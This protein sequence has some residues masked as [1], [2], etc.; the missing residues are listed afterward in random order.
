MSSAQGSAA[1]SSP[2]R[3]DPEQLRRRCDPSIFDFETTAEIERCP[4]RIIGQDR[5]QEALRLGLTLRS[6]GYNIFVTGDVGSGRSTT[7]RRML[8]EVDSSGGPPDD[9]V[10][11]HDFAAADQPR[12]LVLPAGRGRALKR[13]MEELI[14]SLTKDLPK[15]FDSDDYRNRRTAVVEAA[16]QEQKARVKEFE[17]RVQEQGF[18]LVQVQM[19]PLVRPNLVPVVA[20][21]PVE[22]DQLEQLVDEGKFREEDFDAFQQKRAE[23]AG[24]LE[25]L[26]KQMRN[27]ERE[28]RRQLDELDRRLARPLIEERVADGLGQFDA[29][30]LGQYLDQLTEDL[31]ENVAV[32]RQVE[33]SAGERQ[34]QQSGATDA[35]RYQV[36]VVVDNTKTTGRPVVWEGTPSYRGPTRSGTW[37]WV[38]LVVE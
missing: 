18:A 13:A 3:L 5:A 34:A 26:G 22:M 32:F 24:E 2:H 14:E 15:L 28:V 16:G 31:L 4:I 8:D 19:G 11:L 9:V 23:L 37:P 12:I 36:N 29:D 20:G 35:T 10:Y 25:A 6:E 27:L 1:S 33:E 38:R 7:V 21:N 17:G 30:G